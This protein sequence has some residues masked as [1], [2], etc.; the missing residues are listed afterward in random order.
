VTPKAAL[1][2]RAAFSLSLTSGPSARSG[3]P[4]SAQSPPG[5]R[6][7]P[8][9][10]SAPGTRRCP[11]STPP[12]PA[13]QSA[14]NGPPRQAKPTPSAAQPEPQ[15]PAPAAVPPSAPEHTAEAE[16]FPIGWELRKESWHFHRRYYAIFRRP[17][18]RGEYSHLLWQIRRA[19]A[20][21][22]GDDCWRVTL[23]GGS[24]TLQVRGTVWRLQR[25]RRGFRHSGQLG[26]R[27]RP[28]DLVGAA[29]ADFMFSEKGGST[30]DVIRFESQFTQATNF[31][32]DTNH[33]TN[34]GSSSPWP[35]PVPARPAS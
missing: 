29:K 18:Q 22:P 12:Q 1:F 16:D 26:E 35:R 21:H 3:S 23:P 15:L 8:N 34:A 13:A 9:W 11:S 14:D 17:M 6:A 5:H 28:A 20:K 2:P 24:R 19:K 25:Q 27:Q 31:F 30:G 33:A 7:P 10:W 4:Q 32:G